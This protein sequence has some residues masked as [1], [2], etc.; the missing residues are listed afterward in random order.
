MRSVFSRPF[1]S[2]NETAIFDDV[3]AT[4]TATADGE[5]TVLVLEKHFF[6]LAMQVR[7]QWS[8]QHGQENIQTMRVG[9]GEN[10]KA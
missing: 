7:P 1:Q 9:F 4:G 5:L 2:F 8:N 10:R 6:D 3:I